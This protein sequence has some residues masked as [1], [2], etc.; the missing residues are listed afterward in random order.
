MRF[1][2]DKSKE[3]K[4]WNRNYF[5]LATIF[6]IAINIVC[7]TIFTE[8]Y[9]EPIHNGFLYFWDSFCFYFKAAY[10]H[11]SWG[12]VLWNMLTFAI[13]AFYIERKDGT[14]FCA[15]LIL[16]VSVCCGM[17]QTGQSF[18]WAFMM[19][20]MLIDYIFSFKK[21][22]R[23]KTNII[24]G[25]VIL[26]LTYLRCCFHETASAGIS[27][28]WYPYILIHNA[29]HAEGYLLGVTT[30]IIIQLALLFTILQSTKKEVK[31]H[32]INK[33]EK[34]LYIISLCLIL[35]FSGA[36]I[37]TSVATIE[38]DTYTVNFVCEDEEFNKTYTTSKDL[39]TLTSLWADETGLNVL[40]VT[41]FSD[42][43]KTIKLDSFGKHRGYYLF[44]DHGFCKLSLP[45][46]ITI[47]VQI[48]TT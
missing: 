30:G 17:I 41:L 19:G 43:E 44:E 18:I 10:I 16:F 33:T 7:Y 45:R 34:I 14:I 8:G 47:Y 39:Y 3:L 21:E 5:F 32:K 20:Y 25:A 1:I 2:D 4:W 38:R 6:Y 40:D 13:P 12:H 36:T 37:G 26:V 42:K 48:K 27:M 23:N 15:L 46:E 11:S 35:C 28:A 24:V 22:K 29:A 9:Y 31:K